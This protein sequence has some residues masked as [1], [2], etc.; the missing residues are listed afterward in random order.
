MLGCFVLFVF[1]QFCR[2]E[3]FEILHGDHHGL[4][5]TIDFLKSLAQLH[6]SSNTGKS[7]ENQSRESLAAAA[8]FDWEVIEV[9]FW[10]LLRHK[11]GIP[12]D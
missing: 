11:I 1:P 10:L 5:D 12:V 3:D 4:S 8:I 2:T 7:N 9:H 6:S